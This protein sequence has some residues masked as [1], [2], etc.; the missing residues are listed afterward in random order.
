MSAQDKITELTATA[1]DA[2]A[3]AK[4][5]T[6][7]AD[8]DRHLAAAKAA[9]EEIK[10]VKHDEAI[11]ADAQRLADEIG[12]PAGGGAQDVRVGLPI[13]RKGRSAALAKGI[14]DRMT[15]DDGFGRKALVPS[16]TAVTGL[17]LDPTPVQLEQPGATILDALPTRLSTAQYAYLRQ[18]SRENNAGVVAEGALKPTSTMGLESVEEHLR[19]VA[20]LSEPIY[21]Y[22]LTDNANLRS[23]VEDELLDGLRLAIEEQ[24]VSGDGT[25]EH[26][27]GLLNV[28]GSQAQAFSVSAIETVRKAI[29]KLEAIGLAAGLVIVSPTDWEAI[30]LA[31][32]S[33]TG[34]L[35]L[36]SP[37]DRAR[38]R[39]WGVQVVPS[40]AVTAGTGLVLDTSSV[41]VRHDGVIAV[42]W[43]TTG[44]DFETNHVRARVETRANLDVTRPMGVVV[45]DLAA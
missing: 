33:G 24:V 41:V 29:T 9:T 15:P 14:A 4:A 18:T 11:K 36:G 16:G 39:L 13:T 17:P 42:Q 7:A 26:F 20:H 37:V 6:D 5:A 23:F 30:E 3:R 35:E 38:R 10:R 21:T 19:V 31:R 44:D 12:D 8:R 22:H 40:P 27:T 2:L 32:E 28:D 1:K 45:A 25:G 43:G 34:S